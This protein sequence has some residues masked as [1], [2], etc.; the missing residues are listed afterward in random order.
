M[1]CPSEH[2]AAIDVCHSLTFPFYGLQAGIIEND[3]PKLSCC[4]RLVARNCMSL[5]TKTFCGETCQYNSS[6]TTVLNTIIDSEQCQNYQQLNQCTQPGFLIL[7]VV[8]VIVCITAVI[9][10]I[11]GIFNF[12]CD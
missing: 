12:L 4:S 2:R 7:L 1:T 10:L 6:F 5:V 8:L 3:R 9:I 11:I